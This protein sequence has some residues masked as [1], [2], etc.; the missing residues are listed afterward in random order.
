[1]DILVVLRAIPY[2]L[3]QGGTWR[4][5]SI[6]GRWQTIYGHWRRWVK[7]GVWD[8]VL[9]ELAE[10]AAGKLWSIDS[11]SCK[12]HKHGHGAVEGPD[13]EDIGTSRGG[14]NTKIHGLVDSGGRMVYLFLTRGNCHDSLFAELLCEEARDGVH[15]LADKAYDTD[16]FRAFLKE[17]GLGC[18]IPPKANRLN[19]ASFNKKRYRKRHH[20]ENAFQRQLVDWRSFTAYANPSTTMILR[21]LGVSDWEG[22]PA[23]VGVLCWDEQGSVVGGV[24]GKLRELWMAVDWVSLGG[25]GSSRSGL[26]DQ[27]VDQDRTGIEEERL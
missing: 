23:G 10:K 2:R 5:L 11:T 21:R 4:S 13:R 15:I 26:R 17:R 19:P 7:L 16:S 22:R 20:G 6:F 24:T 18:C 9:Q 25:R 1:M 12:V 14:P 8:D 27:T 3:R